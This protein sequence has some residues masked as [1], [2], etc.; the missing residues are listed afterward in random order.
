M[1][2]LIKMV[3]RLVK[4]ELVKMSKRKVNKYLQEYWK[5]NMF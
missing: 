3:M 1:F 5:Y 4:I 2:R